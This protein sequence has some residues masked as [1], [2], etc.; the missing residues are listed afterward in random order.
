MISCCLFCGH[1]FS[2]RSAAQGIDPLLSHL[3]PLVPIQRTLGHSSHVASGKCD[4]NVQ[5]YVGSAGISSIIG[6]WISKKHFLNWFLI[7]K[8]ILRKFS[9]SS[10]KHEA[11][12][13]GTLRALLFAKEVII[14]SVSLTITFRV[15]QTDVLALLC[16][17]SLDHDVNQAERFSAKHHYIA[18]DINDG[19]SS[20]RPNCLIV[21]SRFFFDRANILIH[22]STSK[23]KFFNSKKCAHYRQKNFRKI[24]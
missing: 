7:K 4:S 9:N 8:K 16:C 24:R 18:T 20:S 14:L 21:S 19:S 2:I 11:S 13:I 6:Y 22:A 17:C 10:S 3:F 23:F 5:M 1:F 15:L 12:E